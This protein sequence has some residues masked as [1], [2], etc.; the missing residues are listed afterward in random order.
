MAR[1]LSGFRIA[2]EDP[3]VRRILVSM[4]LFSFFSLT[5]VGLMPA[6]AAKNFGIRAKS[7]EYGLLYAG[8]GLG[9]AAGAVSVGT[10]FL[11]FDKARSARFGLVAFA[12]LL[13]GFALVRTPGG[14]YPVAIALG[15]AYFVTITSMSTVLQ[16][17]LR[18]EVRGRIMALWVMAFGGTVP[19]GVLAGGYA[20]HFTTLTALLL[21]GAVVALGLAAVTDL[22]DGLDAQPSAPPG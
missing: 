2:S 5:F 22:R 12:L 3:L 19:L 21:V 18:D 7:I 20:V 8:F 4:T 16:H 13:G 9:A 10:V 14:A 15:F 11:R 17:H 1:L 6:I